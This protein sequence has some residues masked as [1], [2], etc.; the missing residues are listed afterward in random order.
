[1]S[2]QVDVQ[3]EQYA[4][5][6]EQLNRKMESTADAVVAFAPPQQY[7]GLTVIPVAKVKSRFGSGFGAGCKSLYSI[8]GILA[9]LIPK[10]MYV[11]GLNARRNGQ[12]FS[13]VLA[14]SARHTGSGRE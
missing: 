10:F 9:H 3:P 5:V 4:S 12:E 6:L 1:M 2:T 11:L 8:G 14:R 7:S 13:T